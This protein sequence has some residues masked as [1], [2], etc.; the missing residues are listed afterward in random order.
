MAISGAAASARSC[1]ARR[2]GASVSSACGQ[3]RSA[4][5]SWWL[6]PL[7]VHR[8]LNCK[9]AMKVTAYCTAVR[10]AVPCMLQV[11]S[12]KRTAKL[13]HAAVQHALPGLA[14]TATVPHHAS[15]THSTCL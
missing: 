13:T 3:R 2:A 8:P 7:H 12:R 10:K 15:Y 14:A 4:L 11:A 5:Q 9:G 6:M 1:A